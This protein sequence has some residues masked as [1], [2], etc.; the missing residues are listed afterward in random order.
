MSECVH[1]LLCTSRVLSIDGPNSCSQPLA[2]DLS[3]SLCAVYMFSK[4]FCTD[5]DL[6]KAYNNYSGTQVGCVI[7][8]VFYR[9]S[10]G[11][12]FTPPT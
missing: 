6:L 5:A 12:F 9:K 2:D 1:T 11:S 4:L 8:R 7:G 10:I 3:T